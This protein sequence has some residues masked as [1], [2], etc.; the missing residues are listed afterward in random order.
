MHY[1]LSTTLQNWKPLNQ[2]IFQINDTLTFAQLAQ[3]ICNLYG[4]TGE[5]LWEFRYE[6]TLIIN[7]PEF[8]IP[9]DLGQE[10]DDPE[11]DDLQGIAKNVSSRSYTL[12]DYFTHNK[13]LIFV[14]DFGETWT[15][16]IQLM[17]VA[18]T[19]E[20]NNQEPI[21]VSGTGSYLLDDSG[22]PT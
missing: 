14:Y 13:K 12:S 17:E 21:I 22:G 5:H 10:F 6:D 9:Q 15:F 18:P 8:A 1:T 16:D 11:F 2:R 4:L 7:H 20:T 3:I 19:L